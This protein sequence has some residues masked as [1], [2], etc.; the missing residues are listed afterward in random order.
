[1]PEPDLLPLPPGGAAPDRLF[2]LEPETRVRLRAALWQADDPIGHVIF[3][4]GRTEYLEKIAIPA[5]VFGELGYSVLSL[6]WRGQGLSSRQAEPSMKGHVGSFDEFQRD[7][8]ALLASEAAAGLTGPRLFVCHS[9]GGCIGIHALSRPEI[10]KDVQAA[11]FSA[12]MLGIRMSAPM[13]I[14][15]WLTMRIGNLLGK[16]TSWPPFGD[17]ST[18]YVLTADAADNVLTQDKGVFDWMAETARAHPEAMI[19][20]PTHGW[21]SAS[22]KAIRAARTLD[23]PDMPV[24]FL[25]GLDE[26]VVDADA[27]RAHAARTGS[28]LATVQN[29]KHELLI[30]AEPIRHLAWKAITSFLDGNDLPQRNLDVSE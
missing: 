4:S 13:R 14:A 6:D 30:E 7:L 11:I 20:M 21:F 2:W 3:L 24:L 10:A 17:V 28:C 27:V 16:S 15:A 1:M 9:M 5:A 25:L 19:A 29:G 18:P 12:P 8:D 26:M 22:G 23:A